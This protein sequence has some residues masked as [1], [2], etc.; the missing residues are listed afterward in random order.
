LSKIVIYYT[1]KQCYMQ[2]NQSIFKAY[3]IRG[4][5][6]TEFNEEI[7][8]ATAQAYA[9]FL[10]P[11]TVALGR[12]VRLSGPTIF[13]AVKKGL[14][15]HGVDVVDIGVVSTDMMYFAVAHYGYDGGLCITASHNPGEYNG[16]KMVRKM[17][18][19]ISGES[20]IIEIRDLVLADYNYQAPQVGTV[21]IQDVLGD[22]L[23]KVLSIIDLTKIKP[24]K[25]VAN[26]NFGAI[27]R[28]LK[29]LQNFLS[30]DVIWLNEEPN[31]AFPKGRPDPLILENR[32]ETMEL[33]KKHGADFG[34]AWDADADRIFFI[35]E[36][37][38]FISGYFTSAVLAEYF[39]TRYPQAKVVV[40]MKLNWAIIDMVNK[41]G[42][43]A[44]PNKT[45][46]A[47]FK[48]RMIKEDAVFGGEVSGHYF[49][50]DFFYLDNGLIP[51]LIIL[52][53]L[54][55]SGKKLSEIYQPYFEKYFAIDETN[56]TVADVAAV[57]QSIKAKYHDGQLSEIDGI[58][59]EYPDWRF[60]VRSSNT[61]PVVRLNLEARSKELM[62]AR[63]R[64]LTELIK[65]FS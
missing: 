21:T 24:F 59:I 14:I 54:S 33:V 39:L 51:F 65:N 17:A 49:F 63:A 29:H 9:K 8:Y 10:A 5:Y 64:E 3:D 62:N 12:D 11:K 55:T 31:G 28:N 50:K 23:K 4:I 38:R 22:Y 26:C 43:T 2:I 6:P 34:V 18:K 47:F 42:G 30:L 35:D 7:A 56:F 58:A 41:M 44:L 27:G 36:T 20:G 13:G 19:P 16:I 46:H 25:I 15:D 1:M 45:G 40:D 57:L 60:S 37:G 32:T 53:I 61:E 52:D 48:E